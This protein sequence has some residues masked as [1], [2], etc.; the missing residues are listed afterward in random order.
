MLLHE[1]ICKERKITLNF[2]SLCYMHTPVKTATNEGSKSIMLLLNVRALPSGKYKNSPNNSRNMCSVVPLYL[3]YVKKN[4][5][6]MI[7]MAKD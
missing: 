1:K 2:L 5:L 3:I 4:P 7:N 6:C